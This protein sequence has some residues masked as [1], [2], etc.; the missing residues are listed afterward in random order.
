VVLLAAAGAWAN[1]AMA[2][3]ENTTVAISFLM[4]DMV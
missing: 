4:V 3:P 2:M 1:E